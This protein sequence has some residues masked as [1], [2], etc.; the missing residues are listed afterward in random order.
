MCP[1]LLSLQC[2]ICTSVDV[3]LTAFEP[4]RLCAQVPMVGSAQNA[5]KIAMLYV[6][7]VHTALEQAS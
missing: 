1:V 6:S 7:A 3:C 5:P 4:V 2:N